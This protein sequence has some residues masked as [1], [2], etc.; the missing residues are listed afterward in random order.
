MNK[1]V[2]RISFTV[3]V[4]FAFFGMMNIGTI[5]HEK[6]HYSNL[7]HLTSG[8]ETICLLEFPVNESVFKFWKVTGS[9]SY[10]LKENVTQEQLD[11]T[12]TELKAYTLEAI[13]V[14][15]LF[16]FCLLIVLLKR[17]EKTFPAIPAL[18]KSI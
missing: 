10:N 16:A 2:E 4:L 9:Y 14:N 5:V 6:E 17:W 3:I 15:I 1:T 13:T 7:H 11:S 8:E 12:H 18:P